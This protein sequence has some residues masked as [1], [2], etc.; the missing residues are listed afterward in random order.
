MHHS[1]RTVI[2]LHACFGLG[3]AVGPLVITALVSRNAPWQADYAPVCAA[4]LLLALCFFATR[5]WWPSNVSGPNTTADNNT[6]HSA[7]SLATSL[8][9]PRIWFGIATFLAYTGLESAMGTWTF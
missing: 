9:N 5:Q 2:W 3:A 4:H 1:P 7:S 8:R 6:P